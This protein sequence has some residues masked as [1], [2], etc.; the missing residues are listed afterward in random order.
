MQN[1]HG[2]LEA[3]LDKHAGSITSL[4]ELTHVSKQPLY[5]VVIPTQHLFVLEHLP[6]DIYD[7][8]ILVRKQNLVLYFQNI[9]LY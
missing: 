6:Y 8:F 7:E 3:Q 5:C 9:K 2:P 1:R 4:A